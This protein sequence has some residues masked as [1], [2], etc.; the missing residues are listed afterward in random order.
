MD[1]RSP[2]TL[3]ILDKAIEKARERDTG[4]YMAEN[5]WE[6]LCVCGHTLGDHSAESSGGMRPCFA[7]DVEGISCDCE[8]FRQ[9]KHKGKNLYG[10]TVLG[11]MGK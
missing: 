11:V 10:K 2:K 6:R 3:A 4:R 5:N 8:K 1:V 9:K 7:G